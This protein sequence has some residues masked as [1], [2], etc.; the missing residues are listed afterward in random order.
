M[1]RHTAHSRYLQLFAIPIFLM[2]CG[3]LAVIAHPLGNFTI[4]HYVRISPLADRVK[5][6][7]IVDLAE[8]PAYQE[9]KLADQNGDGGLS[10]GE[11]EAHLSTI[12]PQYLS[13]LLLSRDGMSV[14]LQVVEKS[15]K[16]L[17]GAAEL[18]TMRLTF[19]IE[20]SAASLGTS[21]FRFEN[22]NGIGHAGWYEL[23]MAPRDGVAVFNSTIFANGITDE[24]SAYPADQL[25]APL[26]ERSGSWSMSREAIPEGATPLKRRDGQPVVRTRDRFAELIAVPQLSLGVALLGLLV[27]FILGGAH[28]MSPGHGKTVVGAYLVGSRGTFKHAAFLGLTVTITHTAG[29]FALGIVTLFASQ[30]ILPEKLF[31]VLGVVSGAIVFAIGL[32][33]F[34]K[35][36]RSFILRGS[37]PKHSHHTH[38]HRSDQSGE[39]ENGIA[40]GHHH[41]H[42]HSDHGGHSH[43]PPGADGSAVSWKSLLA[44]GVSGGL[45]PCPSALVVLLAAISL[46]RVAYGLLLIVAF[47]LGL[48]SV[49]TAIGLIFVYASQRFSLSSRI[50]RLATIVPIASA[51]VIT[52]IGAIICYDALGQGDVR[53]ASRWIGSALSSSPRPGTLS[54]LS[55]LGTGLII[56]LKHAV[57][58]D[59]LA[60]ISTIVSERRSIFSSSII[61]G[62]WGIGHT[63]SLLAAGIV[64]IVLHVKIPERVAQGM[65]FC[66]ALMLVALGINALLKLRKGGQ[67]HLHAHIHGGHEHSHPHFHQ[68]SGETEVGTHH[69]F[70]PSLRPLLIGMVH[71]LAG[72]AALMLLVLT[73]ISSA[74]VAFAYIGVFGLGSVGG[75][76][77]MSSIMG[78]PAT[79]A[80]RRFASA[81]VAIRMLA[82]CFSLGFGLF[83]AW[84]IGYVDGLLR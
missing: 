44:L 63:I 61:G 16:L 4:N 5:L 27:A 74:P 33:L 62:L 11:I 78:L 82:G 80:A 2:S 37:S 12:A 17:P 42:G 83:M 8:I 53:A 21:A 45:L 69:G 39:R 6:H 65:E 22:T 26:S 15:I 75:M 7:Y 25:M 67:I 41:E 14:D 30:Y 9:L 72:S 3:L 35:R 32:S 10:E 77:I 29:V 51:L 36:L 18:P 49:L 64:V 48:A 19:E 34:V 55:I 40:H 20:G 31:P 81:N 68:P 84:E 57:E 60:A 38:A 76:M 46:G 71:G 1:K 54:I 47:S 52:I 23:V 73:T 24:L 28:A 58:A 70:R 43:L 13:G 59:H 66:V 79:L 50:G 56:G